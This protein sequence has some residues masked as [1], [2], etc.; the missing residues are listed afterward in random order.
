MKKCTNPLTR[1]LLSVLLLSPGFASQAQ[2]KPVLLD[3][4]QTAACTDCR[5]L[6][7]NR[8]KEVLFGINIDE[9][10]NIGFLSTSPEW[11]DKFFNSDEV[12]VAVDL[13]AKDQYDCG[14][15]APALNVYPK[16]IFLRP[17]YR[18]ELKKNMTVR[19]GQI[20]IP[21]GKVP[22]NLQG[23]DLE[24]NLAIVRNERIC[25][26]TFFTDIPR[27]AWD[28]LPMGL[29]ADT[30]L[31]YKP[32]NNDGADST[33]P[34]FYTRKLE[35]T[36]PFQKGKAEY[37]KA[38]LQPLYDS[39]N[40]T[41]FNIRSI[42]IRAYS[43]AEGS[44]T[45]NLTLQ[46]QRAQSMVNALKQFQSLGID[47]H[48]TYNTDWLEFFNDI[49]STPY[50]DLGS[51][52]EPEIKARLTD[53][54]LAGKME[55]ILKNHRKAIVTV[56]LTGK[57]PYE[58]MSADDLSTRFRDA[59]VKKDIPRAIAI[60]NALFELVAGGKVPETYLDQLE[61]P[62]ELDFDMLLNNREVYNLLLSRTLENEALS[63]LKKVLAISP[64]NGRVKYNICA[65][66]LNRWKYDTGFV[67]PATLLSDIN[68]LN[69]MRI[70]ASLVRRMMVNYHIVMSGIDML[71]A[72]YP[73]KDSSLAFITANYAEMQLE[74][75]DVLALAEYLC[76][77][78]LCDWSE[79]LLTPRVARIDVNED[80]L[81][82][83]VNL[84]LTESNRAPDALTQKAVTNAVSI[85]PQ[86]FCRYFNAVGHGGVTFQLLDNPALRELYCK[87][88]GTKTYY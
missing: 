85:N 1:I 73:A 30:L 77:Y 26:Y 18:A 41:Q 33:S 56:Y 6:L 20:Y 75:K 5:A 44:E 82:Y 40:L 62:R 29:Y 23:K 32:R 42:E 9:K 88:C 7:A 19:S 57:S 78:Q 84:K 25:F 28:I 65:L 38:D 43:S 52:S 35:F 61:I 17:V 27:K 49:K 80:L 67:K 39:L 24:G 16:G 21:L 64:R 37:H 76:Y 50:S 34:L 48:I 74:D 60:Q 59:I 47:T 15:P 79:K 14:K 83:F 22:S 54:N 66:T 12:G 86:R 71:H 3:G 10:G 45:V 68:E 87:S 4:I 70:P 11:F 13:V 36:V 46:K 2:Q 63:N 72:D 55:P 58:H 81:F 8:P 31:S 69:S 53:R 51:L